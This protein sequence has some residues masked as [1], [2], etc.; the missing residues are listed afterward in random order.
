MFPKKK[1]V[2]DIDLPKHVLTKEMFNKGEIFIL[3]PWIKIHDIK[4]DLFINSRSMME[5]NYES[6][7]KY[8][9]IIHKNVSKN[10]Y[11]LCINRYYKDLV[12]YPIEFHRYPFKNN[13]KTLISKQSWMQP[14]I[15]FLF[16]KKVIKKN[17]NIL[18]TLDVIKK[19]YI[20]IVKTDI[21]IFRRLMPINFYRN[22]KLVKNFLFK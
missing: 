7:F 4:I 22:Y 8:F 3:S 5:M 21:F 1:F 19:N 17:S 12:G 6:I 10:G 15:H 13:W 16:V 20:K 9:K 18:S 2:M 14:H 11:F